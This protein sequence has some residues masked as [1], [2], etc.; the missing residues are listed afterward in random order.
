MKT[1]KILTII[2]MSV[3]IFKGL[4]DIFYVVINETVCVKNSLESEFRDGY[5]VYP[6]LEYETTYFDIRKE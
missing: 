4:D 6:C 3:W 5:F 1:L 2:L